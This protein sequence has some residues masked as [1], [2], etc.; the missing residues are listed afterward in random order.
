MWKP[1]KQKLVTWRQGHMPGV[2]TAALQTGW[3][4]L[5]Q[6]LKLESLRTIQNI[7]FGSIKFDYH[8]E[9]LV[10][11][12]SQKAHSLGTGRRWVG[13]SGGGT[14]WKRPTQPS[15]SSAEIKL[16]QVGRCEIGWFSSWLPSQGRSKGQRGSWHQQC[17]RL[18][19]PSWEQ[20]ISGYWDKLF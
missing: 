14:C 13:S 12:A 17:L 6:L 10:G 5:A 8:R 4:A 15:S 2:P 1:C 3:S 18:P 19:L 11:T 16:G 7:L 20:F 9:T